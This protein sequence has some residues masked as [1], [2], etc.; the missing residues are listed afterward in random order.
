MTVRAEYV[1]EA[2]RRGEE[3]GFNT[4]HQLAEAQTDLATVRD[5]MEATN[6]R[7][8]R[9]PTWST[10]KCECCAGGGRGGGGS[11]GSGGHLCVCLSIS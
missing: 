9:R 7:N 4:V 6:G 1:A 8:R 3:E 11:V 10:V 2:W 5:A